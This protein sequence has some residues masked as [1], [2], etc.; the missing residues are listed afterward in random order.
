[1]EDI[2]SLQINLNSKFATRYINNSRCNCV[3]DLPNIFIPSQHHVHVSVVN[4]I[5]PY[6][7]YNVNLSNNILIYIVDSTSYTLNIPLGNY[8]SLQLA[9]FFT[10]NMLNFQCTY[11][12]IPNTFTFTHTNSNFTFNSISTC[13]KTMGFEN[14][15]LDSTEQTMSSSFCANL[16]SIQCIHIKSNFITGNINSSNIYIQDTLCT[17]PVNSQPNSNIVYKNVTNFTSNMYSNILNDI[18]I[19]IVNQDDQILD[20]NGLDWSITL[21]LD[22]VDFVNN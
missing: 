11:N 15:T 17:I 9:L 21:Q 4:A 20:L 22:I 16:Q 13:L 18:V 8:N 6:S 19:K 7:F 2:E 1:M 10:Q 12:I 14:V 5:I 3:F